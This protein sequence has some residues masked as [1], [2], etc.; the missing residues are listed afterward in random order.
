M[1]LICNHHEGCP[2]EDC[3]H[4]KSHEFRHWKKE[5]QPCEVICEQAPFGAECEEIDGLE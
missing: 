5:M 4:H 1:L 3:P 2:D